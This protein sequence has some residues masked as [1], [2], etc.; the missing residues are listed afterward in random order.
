V[1]DAESAVAIAGIVDAVVIGSALVQTLHEARDA[2]ATVAARAFL[3]PIRAALDRMQ[4]E[5]RQS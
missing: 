3:A 1:R 2:D 5:N 4:G